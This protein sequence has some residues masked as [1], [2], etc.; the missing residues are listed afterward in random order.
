MRPFS[1]GAIP[2]TTTTTPTAQTQSIRTITASTT[3][4]STDYSVRVN[5]ASGSVTVTLPTGSAYQGI[6]YQIKKIAAANTMT[7]TSANNI[8]G[9]ASINLTAN[10]ANVTLQYDYA[11]TTWN[12]L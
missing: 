2:P 5:T 11:S 6:V 1:S 4:T 3:L 8:D 9:Q 12:I 7:I 10:D